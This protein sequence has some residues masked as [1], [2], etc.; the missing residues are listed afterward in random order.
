MWATSFAQIGAASAIATST[1]NSI[2]N[3][4]RDLVPAQAPAGQLPRTDADRVLALG[5]RLEPGPS[6]ERGAAT[7]SVATAGDYMVD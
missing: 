3:A 7:G 5:D 1:R 6:S 4:D 2:P